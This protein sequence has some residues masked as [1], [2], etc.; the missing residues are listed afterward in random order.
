MKGNIKEKGK[1]DIGKEREMEE[2]LR[3]RGK[4]SIIILGTER[5][6]KAREYIEKE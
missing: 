3:K 5:T 4:N 1:V 2:I 6:R